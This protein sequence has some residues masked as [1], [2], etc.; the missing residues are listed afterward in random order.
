MMKYG[1]LRFLIAK[2]YLTKTLDQITYE[3]KNTGTFT[4]RMIAIMKLMNRAMDKVFPR[5]DQNQKNMGLKFH[6]VHID[7]S[8]NAITNLKNEQ[9]NHHHDIVLSKVQ[10]VLKN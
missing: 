2:H 9:H 1:K 7:Q 8:N 10:D 6:Y 3:Q 4:L 5:R